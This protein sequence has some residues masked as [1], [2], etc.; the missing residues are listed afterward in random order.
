MNREAK[1]LLHNAE[2]CKQITKKLKIPHLYQERFEPETFHR[3][4]VEHFQT[5]MHK[6]T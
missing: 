6:S 2:A 3:G 1:R 4:Q 5:E